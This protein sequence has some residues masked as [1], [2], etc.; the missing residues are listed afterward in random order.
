[1]GCSISL[2]HSFLIYLSY[3]LFF[4]KCSFALLRCMAQK[5]IFRHVM[6]IKNWNS[7]PFVS[8]RF[9]RKF[10]WVDKPLL[11]SL[12]SQFHINCY[13]SFE[14]W[15]LINAHFI[16]IMYFGVWSK[17][18][19]HH[20]HHELQ[21]HLPYFYYILV[22]FSF[23]PSLLKIGLNKL[24]HL[25]VS[26]SHCLHPTFHTRD[27]EQ[28]TKHSSIISSMQLTQ[29]ILYTFCVVHKV[30]NNVKNYPPYNLHISLCSA[31]TES[32]STC[33]HNTVFP[34][35]DFEI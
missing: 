11:S 14:P 17:E 32:P 28:S 20:S 12:C 9:H 18:F 13:F 8:F 16:S 27:E 35:E 29:I 26:P 19:S 5:M 24:W 25:Y 22:L 4:Q 23:E 15:K 34:G 1:M 21:D 2:T 31:W 10:A 3:F 30:L 33:Q 6:M 7:Y